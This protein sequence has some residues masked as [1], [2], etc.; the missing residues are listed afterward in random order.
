VFGLIFLTFQKK[1]HEEVG[2]RQFIFI[3]LSFIM[4][5]CAPSNQHHKWPKSVPAELV[6]PLK[7]AYADD[8]VQ[9]KPTSS[10]TKSQ[11]ESIA[12]KIHKNNKPHKN[13]KRVVNKKSAKKRKNKVNPHVVV[14]KANNKAKQEPASDDYFNAIVKYE[15]SQGILYQVYSSPKHITDIRLQKG[16]TLNGAPCAGDTANWEL[17]HT[18]SGAGNTAIEHIIVKPVKAGLE[19]NLIITTNKRS[20]YVE[21]KS[22]K[23]TYMAGVSWNYQDDKISIFDPMFMRRP[24]G[25]DLNVKDLNFDYKI[26]GEAPFKPIT[27]FDDGKK[28]TYIQFFPSIAQTELPPLFVMSRDKKAQLV[29]YRYSTENNYYVIDGIFEAAML[30]M[31]TKKQDVVYIYNLSLKKKHNWFNR[32]IR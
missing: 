17:V 32:F 31:G 4:F 1:Q 28:R 2:M 21:L 29:N 20:Y 27:V 16:E 7:K 22:Y 15:Y 14:D 19:T 18:I 10:I 11:T 26:V 3:I 24:I 23:E 30:K 13:T 12:S 5:S 8:Q 25:I 6:E 9:P